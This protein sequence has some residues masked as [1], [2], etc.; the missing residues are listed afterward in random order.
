MA[1]NVK[2][3]VL[4]KI[5]LTGNAFYKAVAE[6]GGVAYKSSADYRMPHFLLVGDS[7]FRL[8]LDHK[9][10]KAVASFSNPAIGKI[11]KSA[12]DDLE[13]EI[14]KEAA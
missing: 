8:E 7:Q 1:K 5:D 2:L 12:F 9:Q 3:I 6:G 11:L 13:K 10:T 4:N 14:L